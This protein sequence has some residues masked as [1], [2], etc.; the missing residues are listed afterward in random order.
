MRKKS[1]EVFLNFQDQQ[2]IQTR[3]RNFKQHLCKPIGL[4][5]ECPHESDLSS[6]NTGPNRIP[7]NIFICNFKKKRINF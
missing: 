4:P 7:N 6:V 3:G 5:K 2:T 1:F